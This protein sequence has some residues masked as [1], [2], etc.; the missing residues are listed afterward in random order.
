MINCKKVFLIL[1]F[2]LFL[3][4]K[5]HTYYSCRVF[6]FSSR[7]RHTRSLCDWSSDVCSS[8]LTLKL[9]HPDGPSP[10]HDP[11][12]R[13]LADAATSWNDRLRSTLEA[14]MGEVEG[15]ATARTWRGYFPAAYREEFPAERATGD[16][17]FLQAALD[18]KP[19]G[20]RLER[21]GGQ[22]PHRFTLRLF[23]PKTPIVL[24]D[25]LPLAENLGLRVLSEAPFTL[26]SPEGGED[27]ALQVL[28]VETADGSAVDLAAVGPRF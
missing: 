21:D 5:F 23:H 3:L 19:F 18:D 8:D 27:V 25:I 16:I 26:A 9:A 15:R 22:P 17:D 7:R 28:T 12:E 11:L 13:A 2:I 10:D 1:F 6:F 14:K 4:V 20:V 24:S